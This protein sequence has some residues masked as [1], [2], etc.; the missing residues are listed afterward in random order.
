MA[1]K[2]RASIMLVCVIA[3][4]AIVAAVV[5]FN[6]KPKSLDNTSNISTGKEL[7]KGC[8][9]SGIENASVNDTGLF[10]L[11]GNFMMY[12]DYASGDAYALCDQANCQHNDA[13]CG[14]YI[15]GT[16]F[17]AYDGF[18]YAMLC[19]QNE[20]AFILTR[21]DL[22][23]QNRM[24]IASFDLGEYVE[25]AYTLERIGE[26][27]YGYGNAYI[28]L[29]YCL[30]KSA[31]SKYGNGLSI[32]QLLIVDLSTG[33]KTLVT[34]HEGY[35]CYHNLEFSA[36]L[37]DIVVYS[38]TESPDALVAEDLENAIL[39]GGLDRLESMLAELPQDY[40]QASW[41]LGDVEGLYQFYM[42]DA[43]Y[44]L[45]E[46]YYQLYKYDVSSKEVSV[47]YEGVSNVLYSE[48]ADGYWHPMGLWTP[49]LC[50][51][52]YEDD[53]IIRF[54]TPRYSDN[55]VSW[56]D[57]RVERWDLSS[58]AQELLLELSDGI[59]AWSAFGSV[60]DY[61]HDGSKLIFNRRSKD[62][63]SADVYCYDIA[64]GEESF[65]FHDNTPY[66]TYRFLGE[67]TNDFITYSMSNGGYEVYI[68]S[69]E[70]YFKGDLIQTQHKLG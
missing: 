47:L 57:Y 63:A 8:S 43:R 14:G 61:I 6:S 46:E 36:I 12:C 10:Y 32:L 37:E 66:M 21:M 38:F 70:D 39:S 24:A 18:L 31:D 20:N 1:K 2:K 69:K 60:G 19:S 51:G 23:G 40:V 16:A 52:W 17:A 27:Y 26:V 67:S 45:T 5:Y 25:G 3:L 13:F 68:F 22:N 28:P 30:V 9:D 4:V 48:W 55:G 7:V 53:L 65:L 54:R 15:N 64:T 42:E 35:D 49:L 59:F 62:G 34:E 33:N 56:D 58:G 11:N 44:S 29:E 41:L 50:E